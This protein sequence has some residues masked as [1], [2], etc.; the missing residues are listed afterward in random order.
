MEEAEDRTGKT[1]DKIMEN[2][3]AEKKSKSKLL[4]HEGRIRNLT[5]SMKPDNIH[6]IRV[7]EEEERKRQKVYL[8][9]L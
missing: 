1:E 7:P 8:S 3:E 6:I 9:K 4:D 2:H 5:D